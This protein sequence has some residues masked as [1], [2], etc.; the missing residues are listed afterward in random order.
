[1]FTGI[2]EEISEVIAVKKDGTN[3]HFTVK[4]KLSKSLKI[5]QSISHNGVIFFRAYVESHHRT[6][7]CGSDA[8]IAASSPA[9]PSRISG[10]EM[11]HNPGDRKSVV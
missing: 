4:S 10:K 6:F 1:M 5:D 11:T 8:R 7:G 9:F 3:M 2:I